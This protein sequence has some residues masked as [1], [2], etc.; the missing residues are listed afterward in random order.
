MRYEKFFIICILFV[1]FLSVSVF[2]LAGKNAANERENPF[3]QIKEKDEEPMSMALEKIIILHYANGKFKVESGRTRETT[4]YGFLGKDLRWKTTINY[5][6]NPANNQG[7][8]QDF[9]TTAIDIAADEWDKYTST[10]LFG[11]YQI[12]ETAN[13]DDAKPDGRTE[14]SFGNYK[15][16]GVIAVTVIWG[17]FSGRNKQI[18]EF[19][20]LFDTDFRWGDATAD[21]TKM[22][23]QNIATHEIGHGLGLKD[24]YNT[25]CAEETMYGYSSEGETK[26]RD[27]GN[28]DIIGLRT[29]YGS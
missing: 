12:D 22:D 18:T 14:M 3:L 21:P 7:L 13:W 5:Y 26:K 19:D 9:I 16:N 28:G 2:A 15:Q 23:L 27:L 17:V 8:S 10:A 11:N 20:I 24:L 1:V 25:A 29:L 6:I 4:C